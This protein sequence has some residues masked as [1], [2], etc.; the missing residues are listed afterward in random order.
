MKKVIV[1]SAILFSLIF[2]VVIYILTSPLAILKM[3]ISNPDILSNITGFRTTYTEEVQD[4]GYYDEDGEI[5]YLP[6]SIAVVYYNQMEEPWASHSYGGGTTIKSSGCGPTS[7]A[8][9]LSTLTGTT[10][11]PITMADWSLKN[12][13]RVYHAGTSRGL[14]P[15]AAKE[16]GV[17]CE[18]LQKNSRKV[19]SALS[20]GRL[21]IA[22]MGPGD[23]TKQ[24]HYIVLRGITEDGKI[25]VA[26]PASRTRSE[27]TWELSLIVNQSKSVDSATGG[28]FWSF[29]LEESEEVEESTKK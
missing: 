13:Y 11:D 15:A 26:D 29:W 2:A 24:G 22:I 4:Y 14:F 28:P 19:V 16:W 9:V 5:E 27:Q 3:F 1:I 6:G 8:I 18:G 10:V 17:E 25:M 7:M 23:F 12:G 20:S 21:V